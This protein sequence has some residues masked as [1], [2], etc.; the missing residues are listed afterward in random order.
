L[1]L[2]G[3][4]DQQAEVTR[5]AVEVPYLASLILTHRFDGRVP[6][7][8][9]W[10]PD[11]RPPSAIIFWSFRVMVGIG[12]LMLLVVTIAGWLRWKRRL[13]DTGWFLLI[14][15]TLA[16]L[17]FAAVI[18]GWITTE[19]GRQP[20]VVYGLLRTADA[21][22]PS[23]SSGDVAVSLAVYVV[24]YLVVYP[25]TLYYLLSLMRAGPTTAEE[26]APAIAGLQ[27]SLPARAAAGAVAEPQR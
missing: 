15:V 6:G 10:P 18:A 1:I 20:W 16:P 3:W 12:V 17:G 13:Y 23:L 8:K 24:V 21:V 26:A 22:T 14:C 2:V 27:R 4:P 7:L 25:V 19:V 9:D 5:W 11:D